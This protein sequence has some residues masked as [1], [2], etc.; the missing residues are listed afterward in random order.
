MRTFAFARPSSLSR[1]VVA[2]VA[3]FIALAVTGAVVQGLRQHGEP[4]QH[5]AAAERACTG[6]RF[7]SEREACVRAWLM[8]HRAGADGPRAAAR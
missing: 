1:L 7:V 2:A 8:A 4:L 3:T 5:L 6:E